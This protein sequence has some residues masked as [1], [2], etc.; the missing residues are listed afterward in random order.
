MAD[1]ELSA[2]WDSIARALGRI[3][4][5]AEKLPPWEQDVEFDECLER[6]FCHAEGRADALIDPS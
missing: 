3:I 5:R 6:A 1:E 2:R 4:K